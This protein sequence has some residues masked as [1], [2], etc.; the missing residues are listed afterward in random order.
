[1][2]GAFLRLLRIGHVFRLFGAHFG[3]GF[4]A[5]FAFRIGKL[6]FGLFARLFGLAALLAF[7][8]A[9]AGVVG[10]VF[11][12][13][14]VLFAEIEI[15]QDRAGELG[16]RFLIAQHIAQLGEILG[17]FFLDER[18]P[19]IDSGFRVLGRRF[20]GQLFAHQQ[21]HHVGDGRFGTGAD[22]CEAALG[23]ARFDTGGKVLR[24]AFHGER[25]YG[26]DARLFGGLED[27]GGI[28][29]LRAKLIV[30]LVF[31]IGAAKR[32]GIARAA[33]HS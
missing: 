32:I 23:H 11:G 20:A 25:A 22:F 15:L 4:V 1:G 18:T 24:H 5:F 28:G 12:V 16:E 7:G 29:R 33:H 6:G 27:R 14:S 30:N 8:F 13:G 2:P 26:L 31:V 9:F 10:I 21:S 19:Q 3:G 17:G